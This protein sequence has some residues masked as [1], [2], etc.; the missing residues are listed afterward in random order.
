MADLLLHD[1]GQRRFGASTAVLMTI[2]AQFPEGMNSSLCLSENQPDRPISLKG[3]I[4]RKFLGDVCASARIARPVPDRDTEF[5]GVSFTGEPLALI[6]QIRKKGEEVGG[7]NIRNVR[8][9]IHPGMAN[10]IWKC[11]R[12]V[13]VASPQRGEMFIA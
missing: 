3:R 6:E 13:F 9:V 4:C 1:T 10:S 5:S 2:P 8:L 12:T 11:N 7:S